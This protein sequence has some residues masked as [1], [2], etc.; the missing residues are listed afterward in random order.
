MPQH[1]V[2]IPAPRSLEWG[3]GSFA[4]PAQPAVYIE[5]FN[6]EE[7][8]R[9][10]RTSSFFRTISLVDSRQAAHLVV[11]RDPA[12]ANS[13]GYTLTCSADGVTVAASS[14]D[15]AFY[16]LQ[17][18]RQLLPTAAF[19]SRGVEG[20]DVPYCA[21]EDEP[22]FAWRGAL[23]DVARHFFS[24]RYVLSYIDALAMHKINRLQLHLTDDQGWR[25]ESKEFPLL[26]TIGA[27]RARTQVK[28]WLKVRIYENAPHGG[29]FSQADI[30]EMVAYASDRGIT[31]VPEVEL[32][33]HSTALLASYPEFGS[34]PGKRIVAEGWGNFDS[35][36]SPLPAV[37]QKLQRLLTEILELFP[38]PWIH[39]GGDETLIE[40]WSRNEEITNYMRAQGLSSVEEL[41]SQFMTRLSDWLSSQGRILVSWDEAFVNDEG[42]AAP[43]VVMAWRGM[44]IARSAAAANFPVILAPID[45]TYF[46]FAQSDEPGERW[47]TEGPT[48]I[49]KVAEFNPNPSEWTREERDQII[50]VQFQVWTEL[51]RSEEHADYMTWPRGV[52]LAEV[53][54]AGAPADWSELRARLDGHLPRL[55]AMGIRYRPLEGPKP[56]QLEPVE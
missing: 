52:A 44:D 30:R 22:A 46:D 53:A 29:Q 15:G 16:G 41:F 19:D 13:E 37:E 55:D 38:G 6:S 50:G 21:I 49:Q 3:D 9:L 2:I 14:A 17:T 10:T 33:G 42:R 39:L 35:M 31:I 18:L 8:S 48:T 40:V 11:A 36:I 51:I 45:S 12:I 7:Q 47:A 27:V 34:A 1:P 26:N 24:K 23:L 4:L 28:S 32:P 5:G 54:W 56:W 20:A 25:V 43:G